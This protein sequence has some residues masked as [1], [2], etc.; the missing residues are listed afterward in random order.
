MGKSKSKPIPA[1]SAPSAPSTPEPVDPK[2]AKQAKVVP[3]PPYTT[4]HGITSP[5]FGSAGSGGAENEPGPEAD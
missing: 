2:A 3:N 5:K 4:K 1:P